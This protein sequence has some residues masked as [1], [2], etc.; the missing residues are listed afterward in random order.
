MSSGPRP[1]TP[2]TLAIYCPDVGTPPR[3]AHVE[4]MTTGSHPFT[5]PRAP[6][7]GTVRVDGQR[8]A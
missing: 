8:I 1:G 2:A 6:G 4:R 5:V 7:T 3:K